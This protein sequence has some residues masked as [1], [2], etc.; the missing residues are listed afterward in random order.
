MRSCCRSR[1]AAKPSSGICRARSSPRS[2]RTI[3]I[4]SARRPATASKT[5]RSRPSSST[6]VKLTNLVPPIRF[7]VGV[8]EIPDS[9]VTEL[10][11]ILEGMRDRRNVRLHLVGHADS[12]PLSPALATVFGDNE[13]LSR[14]RAGEVAELLQRTLLLPAEGISYEWAG[15]QKPV[16]SN[17]SEAG[18]AQNRRVEVEVWYDEVEAGHGAGRGA[19]RAGVPPDQ[20][21]PHGDRLPAALHRRQRAAH[22]RP[23]RRGAV[24]LR[25]RG[26]RSHAGLHRADPPSRRQLERPPQRAREVRRLHRRC[27]AR[28]SATSAST[29]TTSASR[30][31]NRAASRWP[32]RR[33]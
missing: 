11:K 7:E 27:A 9:T 2:G 21:L 30:A 16:A 19:R 24:A 33:R 26:R 10:R 28:A 17:A 23:E 18:R 5:A 6:T 14:E 12:Q 32:C 13:G 3:R 20:G 1:R 8:A 22:A 15:D 4:S 29:A 31:R 25:R